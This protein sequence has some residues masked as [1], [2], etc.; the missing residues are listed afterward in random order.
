MYRTG[1]ADGTLAR[2]DRGVFRFSSDQR[3]VVVTLPRGVKSRRADFI[4]DG[5]PAP[6]EMYT[7]GT[8]VLSLA[9]AGG[10]SDHYLEV[11][12]AHPGGRPGPGGWSVELPRLGGNTQVRRLYWELVLPENEHMIG[13]PG[14]LTPEYRWGWTGF[15]WGRIPMMDEAQLADLVRAPVVAAPPAGTSRYLFSAPGAVESCT[16]RTARRSWIVLVCSGLSLAL[17]LALIY[18][19]LI[20]HPAV[21]VTGAIVLV[22]AAV[23]YPGPVLLLVQAAALGLGLA[24]IAGLLERT[25]GGGSRRGRGRERASSV[26]ERGSTQILREPALAGN[27]SSTA[28]APV[29]APAS[30][31]QPNA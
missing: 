27:R 19:P 11:R 8:A 4:L 6:V 3:H 23:L 22:S 17:G 15:F 16:L 29:A 18:L 2:R 30:T 12:Y 1:R 20:R 9:P 14:N 24:L 10:R 7:D 25:L 26:L 28:S 5:R 21:L 31:P 13:G